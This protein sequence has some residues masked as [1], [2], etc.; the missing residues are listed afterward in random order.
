MLA[1]AT[2]QQGKAMKKVAM[3]GLKEATLKKQPESKKDRVVAHGK[4]KRWKEASLKKQQGFKKAKKKVAAQ[5]A[6]KKWLNSAEM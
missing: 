6:M 5:T 2:K 4:L 1:K 3:R